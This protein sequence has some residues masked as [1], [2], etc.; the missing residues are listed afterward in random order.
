MWRGSGGQSLG[1]FGAGDYLIGLDDTV[2]ERS[3]H[4]YFRNLFL[5]LLDHP[6]DLRSVLSLYKALR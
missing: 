5:S 2:P 1:P 6:N 3:Q 4:K